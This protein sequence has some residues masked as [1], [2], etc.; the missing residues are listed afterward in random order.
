[1]NDTS[2][3]HRVGAA[4]ITRIDE[5]DFAL[6]PEVL[7]PDWDAASGLIL[8]ERFGPASLDLANRRV[9]LKTH[10]WVVEIGDLT[11]IVDTGIGNAKSRPFSALFD[12]LENPVLERFEAAGFR[13]EQVDYVLLT[14]LHVDHVGWNT[15]WRDDRWMPVFP[16]ATYVF[17]QGERDYFAT[18]AGEPRRMVFEDSVLP[19]IEAQ[20]ARTVP[21]AGEEIVDG[22]RFISTP[23][24]SIG[25]MAIEIRS[26]GEAALFSG[27]VMHSPLQVYFPQWNSTF[28]LDQQQARDSRKW[29]LEY[30]AQTGAKVFAAHFPETSAGTVREG[31]EGFE[32]HY[33]NAVESNDA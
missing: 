19:V 32:W 17:S 27:D 23:G 30:A 20:Q 25:H 12:R 5:T 11:V 3:T 33:L 26:Q 15:H 9:P 22:I 8:E 13:R 4:I 31:A 7:F 14:H 6:A 1:M 29:L 24:H 28:C 16:N 18:P 10:L 2:L 21:D